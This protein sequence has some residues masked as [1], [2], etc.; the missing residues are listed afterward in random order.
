MCLINQANVKVNELQ[1]KALKTAYYLF[2]AIREQDYESAQ[3]EMTELRFVMNQLEEAKTKRERL[4]SL[5]NVVAEMKAR[6]IHIDFARRA[7]FLKINAK[8]AVE[9]YHNT[10]FFHEVDKKRQQA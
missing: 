3:L 6:G 8:N 10:A 1:A 9:K 4:Q 7:S 5:L 2:D